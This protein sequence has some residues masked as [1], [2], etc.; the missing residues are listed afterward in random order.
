VARRLTSTPIR[1]V[2]SLHLSKHADEHGPEDSVLLAVDQQLGDG[3]AFR[4]APELADP[5]CTP[6]VGK[7]QDVEQL[8]AGSR[9][10]RVQALSESALN[11]SGLTPGDY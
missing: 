9:A 7:H 10:E 6:E 5:L 3:A 4:I 11:S 8:G 1:L 2:R